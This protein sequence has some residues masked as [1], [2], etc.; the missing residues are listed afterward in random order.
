[1]LALY[2]SDDNQLRKHT[3]LD[4]TRLYDNLL[5]RFVERELLKGEEEGGLGP[6]LGIAREEV[7]R[8]MRRLGVAGVGMFNRRTLHILTEQLDR[9]LAFFGLLPAIESERA[10]S[11]MTQAEFAAWGLLLCARVE[12]WPFEE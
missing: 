5:T 9:D 7:D 10:G 3:A 6:R 2:D 11:A 1:M 12:E 8:N 4:Q